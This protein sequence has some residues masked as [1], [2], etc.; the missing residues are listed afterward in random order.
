MDTDTLTMK[1]ERIH[2]L[3]DVLLDLLI[4]DPRAQTLALIILE[5]STT[6]EA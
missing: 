6:P 5:T 3:A 4:G 1:L 2:H